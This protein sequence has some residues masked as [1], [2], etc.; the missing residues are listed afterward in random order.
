MPKELNRKAQKIIELEGQFYRTVNDFQERFKQDKRNSYMFGGFAKGFEG[1]E[2]RS[3]VDTLY[4]EGKGAFV[5]LESG[6]Y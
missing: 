6:A 3:I 2:R 5:G 4:K 1:S